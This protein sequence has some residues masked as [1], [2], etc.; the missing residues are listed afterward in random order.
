MLAIFE[1]AKSLRG[2]LSGAPRDSV[3]DRLRCIAEEEG[4]V[5]LDGGLARELEGVLGR[6]LDRV[7]W[8]AEGLVLG[9]ELRTVHAAFCRAGADVAITASYQASRAHLDNYEECLK[10]S[11]TFAQSAGARCVAGSIGPLAATYA[12]GSEYNPT[13][14]NNE[15]V[16]ATL[17]SYHQEKARILRYGFFLHHCAHFYLLQRC[18]S[19][20]SCI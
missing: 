13:Y 11:V 5:I 8:T 1:Q 18:W 7:L 6:G 9:D 3:P 19:R 20:L 15:E 17:F 16:D 2:G 14:K 12:D 4:V 10:K